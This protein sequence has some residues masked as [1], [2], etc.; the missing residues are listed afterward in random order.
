[1]ETLRQVQLW[2]KSII[3]IL[4]S[5]LIML[6]FYTGPVNAM[7]KGAEISDK[8]KQYLS[9]LMKDTWDYMDSFIAPQTGFPYDSNTK[10]E[11]TNT[12]NIGLYLASLSVAHELGYIERDIAVS[13]AKRIFESLDKIQ[14]W[15]GLYNNW[16]SVFGKTKANS[17]LSNISDYNKL[18]AG[19]IMIRRVFPELK[20]ECNKILNQIP[21]EAFYEPETGEMYYE[22]NVAE[23]RT[24]N[25]I[26]INRG[27]DK[28]L[29]AFLAVAS[30]KVPAEMWDYHR[31]DVEKRC[32]LEYFMP[33]W[34]GGG[35]FMQYICG[36]F[37][38]ETA[39]KLGYSSANFAF[40]QILHS[41]KIGSPV[42][43]WSACAD[44]N[45]GYLGIGQL[46]DHV[47]TPHAS[48]LAI[49]Y[50]P[51]EVIR[52]LRLLEAMGA[53][54]KYNSAG[55][56]F[57]F[58]FRDAVNVKTNKVYENYLLLDQAMIF[59][60]LANFLED[61]I[62]IRIF[63]RDKMVKKG[64]KRI[65]DYKLSNRQKK[66]FYKYID[67][68]EVPLCGIIVDYNVL[69]DYYVPGDTVFAN[70]SCSNFTR[71]NK[72]NCCLA[73]EISDEN[74]NKILA[75]GSGNVSLSRGDV[76]EVT[77]M[78]YE[79]PGNLDN[80]ANILLTIKLLDESNN[81]TG[82]YTDKLIIENI[83]NL[84]GQWR[85]KTGDDMLWSKP[86]YNDTGWGE[87]TVS[88]NWEKQ[89]FADYDGAVWYRLHFK[90]PEAKLKS[91]ADLK[92]L[93]EI[94]GI[95]EADEIFLNGQKIGS[96]GVFLSE[97]L[98]TKNKKHFYLIPKGLIRK[99]KDNVLVVRVYDSGGKRGYPT[100]VRIA[101]V[102]EYMITQGL[103]QPMVSALFSRKSPAV[104]SDEWNKTEKI[105]LD[106]KY[107]RSGQIQ[108]DKDFQAQAS[109]MWDKKWLYLKL[110]VTDN[111][112]IVK[113]TGKEIY[114]S[115]VL[116]LY[117]D[118]DNSG[119]IWGNSTDFQI[120]ISPPDEGQ[121]PSV[122]AWFQ[123]RTPE[124]DEVGINVTRT[125]KGYCILAQIAWSY[126]GVETPE[127]GKA[128]GVSVAVNDMDDDHYGVSKVNWHFKNRNNKFILG[129]VILE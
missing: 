119:L 82:F 24:M 79:I 14:N 129:K 78:K 44:P 96:A 108:D 65:S 125:E 34:Q 42:W 86:D 16:L 2:Y 90:V 116:E 76:K 52:N 11:M 51:M 120:G 81:E 124:A 105:I 26:Y 45:G 67:G 39:T 10:G 64:L 68:L 80:I 99:N 94:K 25:P 73:W 41:Q 15:K 104:S 69:K 35:L 71:V 12:T 13:K 118:P 77:V 121:A 85:F 56:Q 88:P 31:F 70:I 36:L 113:Y 1:M 117:I 9:Q 62:V 101:P 95:N 47:V 60:S 98:T 103:I 21:W 22:F 126:L 30:G 89:G 59:L 109:F 97:S 66:D 127:K 19:L 18:P 75:S 5:I 33:G 84:S 23:Q 48:V 93:F 123:D 110:D 7:R 6:S 55:R 28:L 3:S 63:T 87:M 54:K 20:S 40:A 8:D 61:D 37:L 114:K 100:S 4:T 115:D 27:E 92:L 53:R 111:S 46:T 43:G 106:E 74:S 112:V 72:P 122:F 58:G 17:C 32:G 102:Q 50:F 57:A 83:F 38:D 91:W 107:I 29:G 49:K 128:I